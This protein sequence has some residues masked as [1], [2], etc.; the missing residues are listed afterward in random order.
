MYNNW[1]AGVRDWKK[2]KH[3]SFLFHTAGPYPREAEKVLG[4]CIMFT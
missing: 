1:A 4:N 3:I 2:K